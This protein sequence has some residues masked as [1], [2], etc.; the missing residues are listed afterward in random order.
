MSC[1]KDDATFDEE[2]E[3]LRMICYQDH[4]TFDVNSQVSLINDPR[5]PYY[6]ATINHTQPLTF[7]IRNRTH[8]THT[9][10][11][12]IHIRHQHPYE[13][14]STYICSV[15]IH[16]PHQHPYVPSTSI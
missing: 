15:N 11:T 8:S 4:V 13:A 1:G 7:A 6:K 16:M 14:P 2:D 3:S 12:N 10:I 5:N 9:I